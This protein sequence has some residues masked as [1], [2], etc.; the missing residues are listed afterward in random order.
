MAIVFGIFV[1][2]LFFISWIFWAVITSV[3]FFAEVAI[4]WVIWEGFMYYTFNNIINA[5]AK[6][7][8]FIGWI[9]GFLFALPFAIPGIV[10]SIWCYVQTVLMG[11]LVFLGDCP[12]TSPT[13]ANFPKI[14][15][16]LAGPDSSCPM[17]ILKY[18][19]EHMKWV[20]G[21]A[22]LFKGYFFWQNNVWAD[23][24]EIPVPIMI[25]KLFLLCLPYMC[26]FVLPLIPVLWSIF[27]PI[28]G[29]CSMLPAVSDNGDG[30]D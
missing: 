19:Y 11:V 26:L 5:I 13:I 15:D 20:W 3:I 4:P 28:I 25:V 17:F 8:T 12:E 7:P 22:G 1:F 29:A 14:I 21:G 9:I 2:V 24:S 27:R 16:A 23:C 30:R 6:I 10:L 18:F